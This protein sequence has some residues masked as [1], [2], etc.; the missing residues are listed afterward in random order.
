MSITPRPL[1]KR[2]LL[3]LRK[4]IARTRI[5]LPACP[6]WNGTIDVR[7]VSSAHRVGCASE[8]SGLQAVQ[9]SGLQAVHECHCLFCRLVVI[10]TLPH[11]Q[12]HRPATQT[13]ITYSK[14]RSL[15]VP[16]EPCWVRNRLPRVAEKRWKG[17]SQIADDHHFFGP[18]VRM[19]GLFQTAKL[20]RS[21]RC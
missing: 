14:A 5:S 19:N 1:K 12:F 9:D 13:G 16:L 17:R 11:V 2:R 4:R 3:N 7:Q 6:S 8:D 18:A 20:G 15:P 10:Y 21:C